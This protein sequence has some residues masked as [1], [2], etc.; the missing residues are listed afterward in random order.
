MPRDWRALVDTFT[1]VQRLVHLTYRMDSVD[2]EALRSGL[3][4]NRRRFY[5]DELTEQAARVGCSRRRGR[6]AEGPSLTELN[7]ASRKDAV[8]IVNTF[9]YDLAVAILAVFEETPTA[10]RYVYASRLKGWEAKRNEWKQPQI[11]QHTEISARAKAQQDFYKFN[12][13]IIGV[14][15]LDPKTA[16]CPICKGWVARGEV[17][18]RVAENNPPPYHVNCPHVWSTKPGKVARSECSELWMGR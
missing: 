8:S 12:S 1:R 13:H 6:L 14:A 9:N 4:K 11:T 17:P 18:I 5:E 15:R 16:I 2:E 3:L 10:N 7:E